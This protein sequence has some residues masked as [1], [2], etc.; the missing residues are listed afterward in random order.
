[1]SNFV[2]FCRELDQ[3]VLGR[4]IA[5]GTGRDPR[6]VNPVTIVVLVGEAS[7]RDTGHTIQLGKELELWD[8]RPRRNCSGTRIQ[9]LG[10]LFRKAFETSVQFA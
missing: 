2:V 4:R 7:E 5:W 3:N 1:M 6:E 8:R 9:N 10:Q